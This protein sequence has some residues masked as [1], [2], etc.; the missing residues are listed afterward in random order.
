MKNTHRNIWIYPVLAVLLLITIAVVPATASSLTSTET[1]FSIP[2]KTT[3]VYPA[4]NSGIAPYSATQDYGPLDIPSAF[5]QPE[6]N[7][8]TVSAAISAYQL[9]SFDNIIPVRS[10]TVSLPITLY[11]Q[12][13]TVPLTRMT[14]ESIDDGIDTYQRTVPGIADSLVIVTVAGDNLFYGSIMLPND[15]IEIYPV[16]NRNYTSTTPKPLHIIYS[17]NDLPQT[18][19]IDFCGIDSTSHHGTQ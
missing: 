17:E 14:I 12:S 6:T 11:G 1:L 19:L 13:Y 15:E 8:Q 2:G 18:T 10:N 9:V 5:L 4:E 3:L 16:Q 7:I